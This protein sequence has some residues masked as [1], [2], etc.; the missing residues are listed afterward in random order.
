MKDPGIH[1]RPLI[2]I[3]LAWIAGIV[4]GARQPGFSVVAVAAF[5]VLSILGVY[6]LKGRRPAHLWPIGL[7][8]TLGYLSIQPWFHVEFPDTHVV[9]L[10]DARSITLGGTVA[11]T[12]DRQSRRTRFVLNT[13]W[14]E[15]KGEI[16]PVTGTIRVTVAGDCPPVSRGDRVTVSGRVRRIRNF[17]NP[18]SFNYERYMA[19]RKIWATVYVPAARFTLLASNPPAGVRKR[20]DQLRSR[21]QTVIGAATGEASDATGVLTAL[22]VG[23]RRSVPDDLR[24]AFQRAGAGHVLAISGLHI[25]T[26]AV[27]AFA[28]FRWLL[29]WF[30]FLLRRAATRK[31]SAALTLV[32]VL[33]YGAVSGMAPSTQRAVITVAVFLAAILVD[34][35]HDPLNSLAIAALVILIVHPPALFAISFQLSFSAVFF[36][37]IGLGAR[38][39]DEASET[40][41]GLISRR[42]LREFIRISLWAFLGTLPLLMRYF[43]QVSTVGLPVN[44]IVVPVTGFWVVPLG[45]M[46]AWLVPIWEAAASVLFEVSSWGL[47]PVI[48]LIRWV[49]Q[50]PFAAVKTV[51]PTTAEIVL[52]YALLWLGISALKYRGAGLETS[53]NPGFSPAFGPRF[54]EGGSSG[55]GAGGFFSASR[56]IGIALA[57]ILAAGCLDAG[58]WLYDRFWRRELRVTIIDVGQGSAALV[59]FPGGN[60]ML[61]D[62]GGF[63]DFSTF[64]VGERIVAPL[65]WRKKIRTVETLVLSHPNSDHLNGLPYIARHF[66]V[67]QVWSNGQSENTQGYRRFLQTIEDN[68]IDHPAFGRLPRTGEI[69]GVRYTILHPQRGF[70]SG[71]HCDKQADVNNNS[72]VLKLEYGDISLLLPG[73]IQARAER[74]VAGMYDEA[75]TS[76]VLV[77]A[78]HG[79][80]TSSC[81]EFLDAVDPDIAIISAGWNN[82]FHFPHPGV[83]GRLKSRGCRIFRTDQHGAV[84]IRTDGR[85]LRLTPTVESG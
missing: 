36:I 39:R 11:G 33:L 19:F 26:V 15:S 74:A 5:G 47:A 52:Y 61:V 38:A 20:V 46:A 65:L 28:G 29:G 41:R 8:F 22:I 24:E 67:Q 59:E 73:D 64:D 60:T 43:N 53:G 17:H 70:L 58:F 51:T 85:R 80:K 78:H 32:P 82:R 12:P 23:D 13:Q 50:F 56:G 16:R 71:D 63:S 77:V 83:I 66:H 7:F 18:G 31:V 40:H 6:G 79:S 1:P 76:Q 68:R 54:A 9:H 4:L 3:L 75:L 72:L 48:E 44:L 57:L 27:V 25:G 37:L 62:G 21:I 69:G 2:S 84:T 45:L 34:R 49:A 81:R 42:A 10:A 14:A 30:P 55:A 35:D